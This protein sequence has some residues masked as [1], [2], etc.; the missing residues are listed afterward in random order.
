MYCLSRLAR[1]IVNCFNSFRRRFMLLLALDTSTRYSSVALCSESEFFGEYTWY[2]GN[3]HSIELFE[4]TQRLCV[5]AQVSLQQVELIAVAIGPGSFN[6]VR[7]ALAMAKALAFA[8][9]KP[10][11]GVST[12]DILAFQQCAYGV[13]RP[14]CALLEAGRSEIY[15]ASYMFDELRG[16]SGELSYRLKRLGDYLLVTPQQLVAYLQEHAPDWFGSAQFPTVLFCG[17]IGPHTHQALYSALP[18][19]SLF[20]KGAQ[21]ARRAVS[22][23]AIALQRVHE[24]HIDD[25]LTLEPLY[26]RRPSITKSTRKQPLLGDAAVGVGSD[27]ALRRSHP[28]HGIASATQQEISHAEAQQGIAPTAQQE[29]SHSETSV[30]AGPHTIEREDSALLH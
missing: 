7:V 18:Q 3:N 17:E 12:L 11:V 1:A 13:Q 30:S 28:P 5:Q 8:L 19:H 25:P 9:Q 26:L 22:L 15:A 10:L 2:S 20:I 6:G 16:A 23:A 24:G 21:A 27:S 14:V 29:I 4:Y